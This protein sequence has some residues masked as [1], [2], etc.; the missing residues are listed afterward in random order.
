MAEGK[1]TTGKEGPVKEAVQGWE[2]VCFLNHSTV[3]ALHHRRS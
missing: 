3:M 1:A 2:L